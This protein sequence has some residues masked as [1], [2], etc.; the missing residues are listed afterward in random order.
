MRVNAADAVE[1]RARTH[2]SCDRFVIG[3]GCSVAAGARILTAESEIVHRALAC[4]GNLV[5]ECERER[6]Q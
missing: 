6:S 2:S 5:G 1:A 3:E 4:G